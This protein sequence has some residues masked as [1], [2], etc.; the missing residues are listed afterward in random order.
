VQQIRIN[1][2]RRIFLIALGLNQCYY[3]HIR[4]TGIGYLGVKEFL[5]LLAFLLQ[6]P[7][8]NLS[9]MDAI[10]LPEET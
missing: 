7:F 5:K 2:L 8:L 10:H 1:N 3:P 9:C 6:F 4:V